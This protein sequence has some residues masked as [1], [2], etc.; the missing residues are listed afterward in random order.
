V[1]VVASEVAAAVP[2]L[3]TVTAWPAL[4]VFSAW[5]P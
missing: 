3:V 4:V 5:V 1:T 2:V